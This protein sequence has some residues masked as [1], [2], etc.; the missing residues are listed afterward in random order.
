MQLTFIPMHVIVSTCCCSVLRMSEISSSCSIIS[1]ADPS[2][3]Y[4]Y[5]LGFEYCPQS[6]ITCPM[7][8]QMGIKVMTQHFYELVV[9]S[10]LLCYDVQCLMIFTDCD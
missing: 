4:M 3:N 6:F 8:V 1:I 9:T 5:V 7:H 10:Y 2:Q